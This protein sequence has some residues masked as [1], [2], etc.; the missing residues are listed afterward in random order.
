MFIVDCK[1]FWWMKVTVWVSGFSLFIVCFWNI[2]KNCFIS[3]E[4]YLQNEGVYWHM[5]AFHSFIPVNVCQLTTGQNF[6]IVFYYSLEDYDFFW[7]GRIFV[8]IKLNRWN[9]K[10][11]LLVFIKKL[12]ICFICLCSLLMC[13]KFC[14]LLISKI[15]SIV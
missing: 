9:S 11:I 10:G 3:L 6:T 7:W 8:H 14:S 12:F 2:N 1:C 4:I 13:L 15:S 5:S